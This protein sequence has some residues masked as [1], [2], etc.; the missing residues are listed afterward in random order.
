MSCLLSDLQ[1]PFRVSNPGQILFRF[2]A[3]F[4]V[5]SLQLT[6]L[7][8]ALFCCFSF[9]ASINA[10]TGIR[11]HDNLF[12]VLTFKKFVPELRIIVFFFGADWFIC[13][14]AIYTYITHN[15]SYVF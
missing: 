3:F 15:L 1:K 12:I 10:L 5:V 14:R 4:P 7:V 13:C 8:W 2:I 6:N 11:A 9:R